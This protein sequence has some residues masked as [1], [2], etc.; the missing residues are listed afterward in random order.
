VPPL[1]RLAAVL[2]A[3]LVA[4]A[5]ATARADD[6]PGSFSGHGV[7][8]TYPSTWLHTPAAFST[9][10]GSA[11]W[12]ESFAPVPTTDPTDPTQATSSAQARDLVAVASYRTRVSITKKTLPR[13]RALIR[14]AVLQLAQQ[15]HGAL[16]GGP[17][18]VTMG[19]FAGYRFEVTA[20]LPDS[21]MVQSRLVLAFNKRTEYFLNCQHVQNGPL[22]DEIEAGCDQVMQSFRVGK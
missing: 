22:S 20:M 13:Y 21:T 10:I 9:E 16:L 1:R 4:G 11:L 8:F 6:V 18:R 12:I 5:V 14:S 15:A 17:L 19:G 7:T 3:A 2:A